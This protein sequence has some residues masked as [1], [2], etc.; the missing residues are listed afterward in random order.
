MADE[1]LERVQ[2]GGGVNRDSE[3]EAGDAATFAWRYDR[4]TV[5]PFDLF[6]TTK[7]GLRVGV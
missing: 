5:A 1:S 7:T 3:W 6:E 4:S 2:R